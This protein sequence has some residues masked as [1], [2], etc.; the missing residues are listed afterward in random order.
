M[1]LSSSSHSHWRFCGLYLQPGVA[2]QHGRLVIDGDD[3]DGD[4]DG[5]AA[6]V[7][8]VGR[9]RQREAVLQALRAVVHVVDH[10]HLHLEDSKQRVGQRWELG[11]MKCRNVSSSWQHKTQQ[12]SGKENKK[13]ILSGLERKKTAMIQ[14]SQS[15]FSTDA[16]SQS[17][18]LSLTVVSG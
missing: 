7:Q 4:G 8:A 3:D 15:R 16:C 13:E 14:F 10:A 11:S 9:S 17:V 2:G 5:V 12:R 18:C 1:N 6:A